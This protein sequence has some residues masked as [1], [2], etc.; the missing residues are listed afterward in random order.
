M[1]DVTAKLHEHATLRLGKSGGNEMRDLQKF[2]IRQR[3]KLW[4][5]SLKYKLHLGTKYSV[6]LDKGELFKYTEFIEV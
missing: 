4:R 2:V 3:H 5:K 1:T 6:R